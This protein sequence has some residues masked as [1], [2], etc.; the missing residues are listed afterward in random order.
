MAE[1]EMM[2]VYELAKE[3][4]LDSIS[5]LDKLNGLN[6]KVK[7]HMSELRDEDVSAARASLGKKTV[8]ATTKKSSVRTRKKSADSAAKEPVVEKKTAAP[9]IRRRVKT[10]GDTETVA[11]TTKTAEQPHVEEEI[12]QPVRSEASIIKE[13]KEGL[14]A[15]NQEVT[16]VVAAPTTA[17]VTPEKTEEEV[18][19]KTAA[20]S[21]DTSVKAELTEA[22]TVTKEPSAA[23]K[24]KITKQVKADVS[25]SKPSAAPAKEA[26]TP[27]KAKKIPIVL[28]P[29]PVAARKSILKIVEPT[30]PPPR[31]VIKPTPAKTSPVKPAMKGT[32]T[33][34]REGY[35]IIKMTKENLDQMVE[36]EAAKKRGG[37][38]ELE[39]RP[40][41]VKFADYRKKEMVFLP[42]KKKIP[43]GKELRKTQLTTPKAIKRVVEVSDTIT[44]QDLASQLNVKASDVIKKLMSLGQMVTM[45]QALDFDTTTL[46]ASEYQFE[47]K[48]V[49]FNEETLLTATEDKEEELSPRPP[50]VTVM[51]HVDHGKT[52]LLDTIREANVAAGEAGGI[53][54][55]I[56][57]YTVEKDG[58]L[59]TFIDTPGHEAF[60]VMR[61]RGANVTDIVVLVVAADDGVMPQTREAINHAQAAGVPIIVAVNKIDKPAANVEKVKQT[62]A[63]LNLLPEDWGGQTMFVPVSAIKKTN[64]EKLIE[65]I[66]LQ[67]EVLDLKANAKASASGTVLEARLEKGR[68][69]VVSVLVKRG[70]LRVG[71]DIVSGINVGRVKAMVDDRGKPVKETAPGYAVEVLG[72]EGIP[73]AGD[74]FDITATENDARKIAETR[75]HKVKAASMVNHG[76]MSLDALFAKIQTGNIKDLGV[77]LKADVFGSVEAIKDSLEKAATEQVKV[78]VIHAGTG[79]ITESD[80]MLASAS[81][82]IIIGFNV[83]PETKA[84]QLA[85]AEKV[86]IKSYSIIYELLDD[87]KKAMA[88][89]LDKKKVEKFLGRAEVRQTFSVPKI[90]V[91]AG[92]SVIDGKIIRGANIRLLR[93]SRVIFDG[94]MSSL[95]RFKDDAKEVATGFECGIG[96]ENYNDLKPGDVIEA[97]QIELVT[98]ELT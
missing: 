39:L 79:G 84:R 94:K 18:V 49:S 55:H 27:E 93:D 65:S 45:N 11:P 51:G 40:E 91:I 6:I 23:A 5:L 92:S 50:V 64:I 83:R 16:E 62:L 61:A 8:L 43:V 97:Y 95:K 53:T 71:E 60:T 66:L 7:N 68:G 19:A 77:I 90:G 34:D 37:G 96:I 26:L 35:R 82:A 54:Q 36:E 85:E 46:V 73:N 86:E 3:L 75:L 24:K 33:Q 48:N 52:S 89:L 44:V 10:D 31:P 87:I 57:A 12:Q 4:G 22:V 41:D 1:Q 2:K 76:K 69:P 32:A 15:G 72:F 59:V 80:V 17:E 98:P 21:T 81:N 58:K 20:A 88:G 38:R 42:K 29:R 56:G 30:I 25:V 78:S 47:V 9:V 28:T 74:R 14:I 13:I 67:A 70:T 63:E